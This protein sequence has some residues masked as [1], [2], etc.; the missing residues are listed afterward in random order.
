[1]NGNDGQTGYSESLIQESLME[2]T[3]RGFRFKMWTDDS[4]N[5]NIAITCNRGGGGQITVHSS[6]RVPLM[7]AFNRAAEQL[8]EDAIT[9]LVGGEKIGE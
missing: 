6:C 5:L 4:N 1:M 9:K 7:R 2:Y 8:A 3:E